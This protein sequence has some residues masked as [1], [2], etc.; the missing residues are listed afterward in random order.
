MLLVGIR[1][2]LSIYNV[3]NFYLKQFNR[4][5]SVDTD[6]VAHFFQF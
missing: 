3:L 1:D 2:K 6:I 4:L 5:V